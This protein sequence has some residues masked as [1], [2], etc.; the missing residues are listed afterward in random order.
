MNP[1]ALLE[2][3]R[4]AA[5]H[6]APVVGIGSLQAL[7]ATAPPGDRA[8]EARWLL[9]V[10]QGSSGLF[11]SAL[12]TLAPLWEGSPFSGHAHC[13]AG[14]LYRQLG[15]F[16]LAGEH[17]ATAQ[18]SHSAAV[19]C[20]A[21][22]GLTADAVGRADAAAARGNL[23]AAG[24][25]WHPDWWREGIRLHWVAAE[26]AL[27]TDTLDG[28]GAQLRHA[29]AMAEQHQAPRHEAKTR[30]FLA[31]VER[32]AAPD[33]PIV[34][35]RSVDLVTRAADTAQTLAAWPLVWSFRRLQWRWLLESDAAGD[36]VAAARARD[37]AARAVALISSDLPPHLRAEFRRR[38]DV[39]DLVAY[40]D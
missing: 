2:S 35:A 29:L 20:E 34:V 38:P 14:S 4:H 12:S 18:T 16:D 8:D 30:G 6:G 5:F 17:D 39:V 22:I 1:A 32:C 3:G 15:D 33:D 36:A 37:Q 26:C 19:R 28:A 7:L 27:L 9:G 10:C 23:A 21:A 31:V 13:V 25:Q 24:E 40:E 11:G